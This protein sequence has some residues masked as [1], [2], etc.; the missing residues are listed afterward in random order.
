MVKNFV[1]NSEENPAVNPDLSGHIEDNVVV[2]LYN[3][4]QLD[5]EEIVIDKD[6]LAKGVKAP[7]NTKHNLDDE[8]KIIIF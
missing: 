5:D 3:K 4:E 7:P 8:V 1:V 6:N 2:D